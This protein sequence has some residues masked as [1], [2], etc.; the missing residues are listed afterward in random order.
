VSQFEPNSR[1]LVR[2]NKIAFVSKTKSLLEFDELIRECLNTL[3]L[4]GCLN[5][6]ELIVSG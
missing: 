5:A 6:L 1:Q 4:R 2:L 3:E